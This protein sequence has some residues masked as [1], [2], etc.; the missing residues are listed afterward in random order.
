M[1]NKRSVAFHTLGC[2]LNF[3][4]T[5]SLSKIFQN[6]GFEE[7]DFSD[8][9]DYYVINTCSVTDQADKKCRKIIRKAQNQNPTAKIV[10]VGC[11]AQLKPEE[12]SQIPGVNLVLGAKEKFNIIHHVEK[13][14]ENQQFSI[15]HAGPV[16]EVN[17]FVPS[18]SI[19]DRT[20]SFLKVQDGCDYKCS[21]CTIPMARGKSRSAGVDQIVELAKQIIDKGTKEIVL[22]G[23]NI[24]DFGNGTSIIE[25]QRVKKEATL[26]DLLKE[27]D[28]I[29]PSIR[30]RISSI[31]PNLC[32]DEIIEF[33]ASSNCFMPHFHM[34]LQSG[35]NEILMAM[36]RRYKIDLYEKRVNKIKDLIAHACIGVDVIVG[37]PGEN[38]QHFKNTYQFI[39]EM[40]VSYL[41]CFTYAE[42]N[43]TIAASMADKVDLIERQERSLQLRTLS[44]KK[45]YAFYKE[46]LNQ[47]RPV[48]FESADLD[49]FME[50]FTDNYIKV[51]SPY[52]LNRANQIELVELDNLQ[53]ENYSSN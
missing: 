46:H 14:E 38:R 22:T 4:E 10:I 19:E 2:K 36:K 40:P 16:S 30:I 9:A 7:V 39:N 41:H 42:R 1:E 52:K 28:K 26:I 53:E 5:S 27:L 45:K 31:E 20:R 18:Y 48:L 24:G 43:N 25:G 29:D 6:A 35:D 12:I 37:F 21:F 11:Y 33:V 50:G 32:T 3:S 34:P 49:G 47:I 44:A 17:D 23:V 8:S 15:V 13:L 51:R